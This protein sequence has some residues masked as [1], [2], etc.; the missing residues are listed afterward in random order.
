MLVINVPW[1]EGDVAALTVGE[2]RQLLVSLV[3][4]YR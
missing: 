3:S 1:K 2:F 4:T